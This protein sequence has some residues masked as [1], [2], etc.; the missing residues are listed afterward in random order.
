[1]AE[2]QPEMNDETKNEWKTFFQLAEDNLPTDEWLDPLF[3][4]LH[5][6]R[7]KNA[8]LA[9]LS[10]QDI[11][12]LQ[13]YRDLDLPRRNFLKR[14]MFVARQTNS[15]RRRHAETGQASGAQAVRPVD[16]VLNPM[17]SLVGAGASASAVATATAAAAAA[18]EVVNKKDL[19]EAAGVFGLKNMF[20]PDPRVWSLLTKSK[21]LDEERKIKHRNMSRRFVYVDFTAEEMLPPWMPKTAVQGRVHQQDTRPDAEGNLVLL[22][23]SI[24]R[25]NTVRRQLLSLAMWASI[26]MRWCTVA[27]PAQIVSWAWVIAHFCTIMKIAEEQ[28]AAGKPECKA[29]M[30][31][32]QARRVWDDKAANEVE[33]FD[34]LEE[35]SSVQEHHGHCG[36]EDDHGGASRRT[37]SGGEHRQACTGR[38]DIYGGQGRQLGV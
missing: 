26:F 3:Q 14:C 11:E 5:K 17:L 34:I 24:L 37:W 8:D 7:L 27:V 4:L 33:D 29:W 18:E 2:T 21:K 35:A 10:E 25:Q 13:D 19:M 1:M 12:Q 23:N 32:E 28:R 31:C 22:A 38:D 15:V 6:G 30:Y 36:D 20:V 9:F 16:E